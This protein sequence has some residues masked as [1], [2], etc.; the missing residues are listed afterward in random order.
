M[1]MVEFVPDIT[2]GKIKILNPNNDDRP[3]CTTD[4]KKE[5]KQH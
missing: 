5:F 2:E 3:T 4:S 1:R